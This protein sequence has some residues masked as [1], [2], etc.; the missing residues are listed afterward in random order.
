MAPDAD[1]CCG[2]C[3]SRLRSVE[4][5]I[6]S[7]PPMACAVTHIT[8]QLPRQTHTHRVVSLFS[9]IREMPKASRRRY[10]SER[11]V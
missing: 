6:F 2:K 10:R 7:W 11:R 5:T 1:A 4:N 9:Q 8:T 3:I